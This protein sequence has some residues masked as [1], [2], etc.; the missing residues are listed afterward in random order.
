MPANGKRLSAVARQRRL[1]DAQSA[2]TTPTPASPATAS[3]RNLGENA[4]GQNVSEEDGTLAVEQPG[5]VELKNQFDVLVKASTTHF[6][7]TREVDQLSETSVK[8][9]LSRGQKCVLLGTCTLWV[10]QGSIFIYGAII[11][12][13]TTLHRI[14]APS[15]HA[16]PSIEAMSAK[17][18]FQVESLDDAIRDLPYIGIRDLWTPSGVEQAALTFYILGHSFEPDPKAP[19]RLKELDLDPWKLVLSNLSTA[20]PSK[21]HPPR[22]LLC[23]RRSSGL[24]TFVRCLLNRLLTTQSSRLVDSNHR[25]AVLVD[26]DANLPEF[27][28]PGLISLVH[29]VNPAYG[30][31]FTHVLPG[32][33]LSN[34]ILR[35]YFLG[36][37][38]I[39]EFSDWHIGR[40]HEILDH[41]KALRSEYKDSPVI[42]VAPRWV[43]SIDQK[44]ASKLWTKILPTDIVCMDSS[45]TS[46]YLQ[47]WS[48]FAEKATCQIYQ[49]PSHAFDKISPVREHELQ[50]QSYF[51]LVESPID[52]LFWDETPILAGNQQ[53]L[54]LSYGMDNA[55]V[56]AIILLGG[57][58]ALEDTYDALEGSIVALTVVRCQPNRSLTFEHE[59]TDHTD[60]VKE[61][62][63][64][65]TKLPGVHRTTEDLP[66]LQGGWQ[67]PFPTCA[68]DSYCIGLAIVTKIDVTQRQIALVTGLDSQ[69]VQGQIQGNQV[70]LVLHK[71]TSDG[72]FKTDWARRE[73]WNGGKR[74]T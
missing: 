1:R 64:D 26:L 7:S 30:P 13:S 23:G 67:S 53:K 9:R 19:K 49:L 44:V 46:P 68:T 59:E 36:D 32:K 47:P 34:R 73:M 21:P 2:S 37:L 63:S 12:A 24:S 62:L 55:D 10:K 70:A 17:A 11:H 50:M 28:P 57:Q 41:V 65:E 35:M 42:V 72:R 15:S 74:A 3:E 58:V 8:I 20:G 45:P 27:A 18:E 51:H 6:R 16:L 61:S 69:E 71:A 5:A 14:Y 66:R 56:C 48:S 60:I 39:T 33:G 22:I 4:S 31:P 43:N 52:R 40:V 25:G 38:D 29:V 54:T